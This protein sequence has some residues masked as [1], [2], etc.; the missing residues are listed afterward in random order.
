LRRK[1]ADDREAVQDDRF[2]FFFR[3]GRSVVGAKLAAAAVTG[4][5]NKSH[6]LVPIL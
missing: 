1:R 5:Q 2:D 3:A 6:W 4:I